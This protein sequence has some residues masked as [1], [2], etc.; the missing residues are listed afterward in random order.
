MT[1]LEKCVGTFKD[2][3]RLYL[4]ED[5]NEDEMERQKMSF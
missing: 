1:F 5:T 4:V 3:A 2:M